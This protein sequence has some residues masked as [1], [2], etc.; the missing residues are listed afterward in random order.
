MDQKMKILV[1]QK[2]KKI[3]DLG[4]DMTNTDLY[5]LCVLNKMREVAGKDEVTTD[6]DK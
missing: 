6:L 4:E 3:A 5:N 2:A 1:D